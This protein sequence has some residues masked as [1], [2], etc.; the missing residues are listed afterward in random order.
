[1]RFCPLGALSMEADMSTAT[2]RGL[3]VLY[4][5]W[6]T[7]D[8][9]VLLQSHPPCLLSDQAGAASCS[10]WGLQCRA[11]RQPRICAASGGL[12]PRS[13]PI[14]PAEA[15]VLFLAV[16][17]C[18]PELGLPIHERPPQTRTWTRDTG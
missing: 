7:G 12:W 8:T 3:S 15:E 6:D 14:L 2:T 13:L 11:M 9:E 18:Q 17:L 4:H 10:P 16:L 5:V 1:M